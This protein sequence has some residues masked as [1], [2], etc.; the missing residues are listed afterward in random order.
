VGERK[1]WDGIWRG[2]TK[3]K[4]RNGRKE[5]AEGNGGV[6]TARREKWSKCGKPEQRIRRSNELSPCAAGICERQSR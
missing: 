6:E 5:H 3:V 1:L 2:Q 4:E